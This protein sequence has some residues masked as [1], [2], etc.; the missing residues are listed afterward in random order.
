[1]DLLHNA[2]QRRA[3]L[4][5]ELKRLDTWIA[6]EGEVAEV[7]NAERAETALILP[8]PERPARVIREFSARTARD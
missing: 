2:R 3:A 4:V 5:E 1:M 6:S 7:G 8:F